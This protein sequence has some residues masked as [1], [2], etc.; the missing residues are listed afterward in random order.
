MLTSKNLIIEDVGPIIKHL[1]CL[2]PMLDIF[3]TTIMPISSIHRH[4]LTS[5][6]AIVV[7]TEAFYN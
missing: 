3:I 6:E 1:V 4:H 5:T 7:T 2:V